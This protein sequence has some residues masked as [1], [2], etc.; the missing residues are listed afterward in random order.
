MSERKV[1]EP[2]TAK[3]RKRSL[4][5]HRETNYV[6]KEGVVKKGNNQFFQFYKH[7]F[8]IMQ[9]IVKDNPNAMRLFFWLVDNMDSNNSIVV[10]QDTLAK[11]LD[12]SRSSVINWANYLR[13]KQ[14]IEILK[15][16]GSNVYAINADIVWCDL[17]EN[18]RFA[19]F[20]AKVFI[21]YEEQDDIYKKGKRD[22]F[23]K[24]V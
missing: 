16:G 18:K 2:K 12:C 17:A 3:R 10:S 24:V 14:V 8:K 1:N 7:N 13:E 15:T 20:E 19:K 22:F 6:D 21:D 4:G 9:Q 5:V 11:Y 23:K